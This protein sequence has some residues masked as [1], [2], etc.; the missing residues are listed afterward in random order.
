M[1]VKQERVSHVPEVRAGSKHSIYGTPRQPKPARN[2]VVLVTLKASRQRMTKLS[3]LLHSSLLLRTGMSVFLFHTA[4]TDHLRNSKGLMSVNRMHLMMVHHACSGKIKP[5]REV[6]GGVSIGEWRVE[7]GLTEVS[8][9]VQRVRKV[10]GAGEDGARVRRNQALSLDGRRSRSAA[11]RPASSVSGAR[12]PAAAAMRRAL[13][14]NVSKYFVHNVTNTC[15][16]A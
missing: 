1:T 3:L 16:N 2:M 8:I 10:H 12:R 7:K 4:N 9:C 6:R 13:L 14:G 15:S 11:G 5:R